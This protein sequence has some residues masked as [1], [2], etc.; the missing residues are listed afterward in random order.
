MFMN[1]EF[2]YLILCSCFTKVKFGARGTFTDVISFF[3]YAFTTMN[4]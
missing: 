4:V 2:M 1:M 3:P